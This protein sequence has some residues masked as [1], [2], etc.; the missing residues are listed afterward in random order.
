MK[1]LIETLLRRRA[2]RLIQFILPDLPATGQ[3]LDVGSGTGHNA[4]SLTNASPLTVIE[5]DVV[6]LHS[7]GPGPIL[8]DGTV[9]PFRD[10][11]FSASILL[12]VLQYTANP[13][14]LLRETR[15]VTSGRVMVLQSTYVGKIGHLVLTAWDFLTGRCPLFVAGALGLVNSNTT[16]LHPQR[17]FTRQ[18]L[19]SIL[20]AS[21]F[22]IHSTRRLD[23][24]GI[25]IRRE[26]YV[27]EPTAT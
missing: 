27:L 26:L 15:R 8:F 3:I 21:G 6:D 9:L 11:E 16:S 18:S 20:N 25:F 22:Q 12:F 14:S 2:K 5:A 10:A 4:H 13:E 7:I 23:A 1:W 19:E 24:I 17:F